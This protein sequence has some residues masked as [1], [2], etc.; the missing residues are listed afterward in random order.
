MLNGD[1]TRRR[2]RVIFKMD[3]HL[4]GLFSE[5]AKSM[6]ITRSSLLT[7]WIKNCYN[8]F[9]LNYIEDCKSTNCD[10]YNFYI[11]KITYQKTIGFSKKLKITLSSFLRRL[12][13]SN[14]TGLSL[15][16]YR[17]KQLEP[18]YSELWNRGRMS[19]IL[20]YLGED[21]DRLN[22]NQLFL[23][24]RISRELWFYDKANKALERI[25]KLITPKNSNKIDLNLWLKMN[26]LK[27]EILLDH[28]NIELT[29][30]ITSETLKDREFAYDY[31]V[32][33]DIYFQL[34]LI[35][36]LEGNDEKAINFMM[37]ALGYYSE[38]KPL[39]TIKTYLF[40]SGLYLRCNQTKLSEFFIK[41]A[42]KIVFSN[43]ENEY[44]KSWFYSNLGLYKLITG[45]SDKAEKIVHFAN[46][47]NYQNNFIG[48]LYRGN[49]ILGKIS[50][51]K[52]DY[53]EAYKY[54][55]NA[56]YLAG[57]Y[58][59]KEEALYIRF[60]KLRSNPSDLSLRLR[61]LLGNS[62][63][64]FNHN[65][66]SYLLYSSQFLYGKN[67]KERERGRYNLLSLVNL[68]PFIQIRKSADETLKRR[69][70]RPIVT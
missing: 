39:R 44:L 35:N 26:L 3:K 46:K 62:G 50:F 19:E 65:L 4:Y 66:A 49:K 47:V 13:K 27:A 53:D 1:R 43:N 2:K 23:Y 32:M 11:D 63:D 24:A 61:E 38:K 15:S 42:K 28:K 9:S 59:N 22:I 17:K 51:M 12:L 58:P 52:K 40:L 55:K 60:I 16:L 31:C 45:E 18:N 30:R 21:L 57:S 10:T 8:P 14:L 56:S 67:Y 33:G 6:G 69:I 48:Q 68:S 41:K 34:G 29:K 54:F 36:R 64:A 70:L 20:Y 37:K 25:E 7:T 5:K